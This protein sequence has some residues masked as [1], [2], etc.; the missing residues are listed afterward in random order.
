MLVEAVEIIRALWDGGYVTYR[1]KHFEVESAKL[2]DLPDDAPR[3]SASPCPGEQSCE[4]AGATADV[5]I[6]VEPEAGL[7]RLFDDGRRD[8]QA[9]GRPAAGLLR[10]RP[11]RG[12]SRGPTSSSAGSPAVWKV[13]A[14]LP[15][16]AGVRRRAPSSCGR[17]DVAESIPC[18]PDVDELVEAVDEFADAGFTHLAL[19]QVGGDNR[20][21]HRLG[22][23]G[24]AARPPPLAARRPCRSSRRR[25][26]ARSTPP[27]SPSP[28]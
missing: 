18:G 28:G 23:E 2:W 11:G 15:G 12:R 26:A 24:A 6:A 14:E 5:M 9:H 25:G 8:G 10:P 4:L 22:R 13:N 27:P 20:P 7:V 17:D 3:R 19:V 16:T 21:V 1:G